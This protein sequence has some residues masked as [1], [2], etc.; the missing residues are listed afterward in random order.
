[1]QKLQVKPQAEQIMYSSIT[2]SMIQM[3]NGIGIMI[4]RPALRRQCFMRGIWKKI[5]NICWFFW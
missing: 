3:M 2:K 4:I 1:M 5:Q